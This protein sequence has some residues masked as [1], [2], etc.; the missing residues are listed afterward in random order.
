MNGNHF[1]A[2]SEMANINL[3]DPYTRLLDVTGNG[4]PDLVMTEENVFTWFAA[5]GKKGYLPAEHSFKPLDEEQGPALVF[6]D[7]NHQESIFLADMTGDGL[8]DI[9]R[10]RNGE[11][12]YWANK[13]YGKFSAKVTMNNAPLF[14]YPQQFNLKYL[15]LADV[16]GTGAADIIYLGQNSF[17]ALSEPNRKRLEQCP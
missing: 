4:Q 8:T 2:F 16:S 12:C 3:N 14:D 11:I 1:Q 13:G 5:N 9:V 6:A 15:Q 10:I 7:E 17:K